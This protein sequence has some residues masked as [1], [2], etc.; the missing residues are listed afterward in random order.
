MFTHILSEMENL[1]S[2][3]Y[4]EKLTGFEWNRECVQN[5][6]F[7]IYHLNWVYIR[8]NVRFALRLQEDTPSLGHIIKYDCMSCTYILNNK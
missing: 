4:I 3:F 1:L 8:F 6:V 5:P 7:V 2:M